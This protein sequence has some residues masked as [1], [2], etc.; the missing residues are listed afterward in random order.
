[1]LVRAATEDPRT[2][3][4]I[5]SVWVARPGVWDE[6][7]KTLR[8]Q[9]GTAAPARKRGSVARAGTKAVAKP[10]VKKRR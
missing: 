5:E 2:G 7:M 8:A 4:T 1:V 3:D 6:V 9:E 10:A